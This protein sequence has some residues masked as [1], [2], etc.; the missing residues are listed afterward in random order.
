MSNTTS[1]HAIKIGIAQINPTVGDL[2]GNAKK[3]I[4]AYKS[5]SQQGADLVVLPELA[6]VGYPPKAEWDAELVVNYD[7]VYDTQAELAQEEAF[8]V[9][10]KVFHTIPWTCIE[11]A[12]YRQT[13]IL[14]WVNPQYYDK[15]L[16]K[17]VKFGRFIFVNIL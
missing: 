13:Q 9:T 6:I 15:Y 2:E 16:L 4:E 7:A 14:V 11:A 8:A 17:P 3:I 5:L 12:I 1:S 10:A